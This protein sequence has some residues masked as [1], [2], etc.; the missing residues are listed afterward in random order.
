MIHLTIDD[1]PV[2]AAP[3][4]TILTAAASIGIEIP[5]LC[6]M[7]GLPPDG[8]CR[9][10][11]V[12]IF[13]GRK[14][15]LFTSCSEYCAEGMQVYTKSEKVIAARRFVLDLLMSN[16]KEHCF[17]CPQNG[18]CRLQ[19]YCMEY[20]IE[21]TS[22]SGRMIDMP[23]DGS[24][25][26]FNYDPKLC[27]MCRRC[28]RTCE[29]ITG[30]NIIS[31]NG[32]GFQTRMSI[33]Y[34]H[35][36]RESACGICGSCVEACPVGALS[37][38]S[39]TKNYR[40][41]EVNKTATTCTL[42][43]KACQIDLITK[44]NKVYD[45]ET[46][47][48]LSDALNLPCGRGRYTYWKSLENR[49]TEPLVRNKETGSFEKTS[50]DTAL[51]MIVSHLGK[52]ARVLSCSST[53]D[54]EQASLLF[55]AEATGTNS[56]TYG[57]YLE[58]MQLAKDCGSVL[59]NDSDMASGCRTGR[60]CS[61]CQLYCD[62]V[63]VSALNEM[64]FVAVIAPAMSDVAKTADVI[65]PGCS[66]AELDGSFHGKPV[67]AAVLPGMKNGVEELASYMNRA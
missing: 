58:L 55:V 28:Q 61:Y 40:Q 10:C 52:D 56:S 13:G 4:T 23:L 49:I 44:N 50:W 63:N 7:E 54:N 35:A 42:C 11:V 5:T 17:N 32:R 31:L 53:T 45:I 34:D 1:I 30:K 22:Y 62:T 24:S 65:L 9:L 27:I 25:P 2:E 67:H 19:S 39:N 66:F 8:S 36:W 37:T 29:S 57:G 20:G 33:P 60:Y 64:S 18:S 26:F 47:G 14:K 12:E 43:D 59:I 21:E 15:G 3:E 48:G 6:F 46:T 38:K 41:W 16:H 51:S